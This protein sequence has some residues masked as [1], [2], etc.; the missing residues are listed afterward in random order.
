MPLIGETKLE[1]LDELYD[2]PKN[3]Y[4]LSEELKISSGYVYRHLE[5]LEEAGMIKIQQEETEGRQQKIY[6]VTE[7]GEHL[8]KAF[9]KL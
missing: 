9:D 2:E 7:N 4:Q 5:D 1:I 6:R 8:L 3:G